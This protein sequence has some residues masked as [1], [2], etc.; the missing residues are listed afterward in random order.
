VKNVGEAFP[1]S[2]YRFLRNSVSVTPANAAENVGAGVQIVRNA[3]RR[4]R[5]SPSPS[6]RPSARS[7][8]RSQLGKAGLERP[9]QRVDL[10]FGHRRGEHART[11]ADDAATFVVKVIE[12]RLESARLGIA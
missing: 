8:H 3:D 9:H 1:F 11:R 7:A 4:A 6:I 12:Q 5:S 2:S 10:R